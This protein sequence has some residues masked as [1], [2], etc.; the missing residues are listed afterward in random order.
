MVHIATKQELLLSENEESDPRYGNST[1]I[2]MDHITV[3]CSNGE[4][5]KACRVKDKVKSGI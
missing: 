3:G 4:N 1:Y 5:R 2:F